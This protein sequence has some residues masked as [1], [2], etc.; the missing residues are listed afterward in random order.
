MKNR[1]LSVIGYALAILMCIQGVKGSLWFLNQPSNVWMNL[2]IV[3][4]ALLLTSIALS[5]RGL[6]NVALDY[7]KELEKKEDKNLQE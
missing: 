1:K 6:I 5:F 7:I 2:G 3:I 4:I